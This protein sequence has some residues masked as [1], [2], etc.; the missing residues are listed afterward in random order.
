MR[1][2][3]TFLRGFCS[4]PGAGE[5]VNIAG[6][7]QTASA[8]AAAATASAPAADD[9]EMSDSDDS[10]EDMDFFGCASATTCSASPVQCVLCLGIH[11]AA[12]SSTSGWNDT[13]CMH[14]VCPAA[15]T[16][17]RPTF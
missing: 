10:D 14:I 17:V 4:F 7:S 11:V 12:K 6:Q 13:G 3:I 5:G 8:P 9:E 2:D 1:F 16:Q 15:F